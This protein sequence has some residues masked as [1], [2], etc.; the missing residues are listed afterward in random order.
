MPG[1]K[2]SSHQRRHFHP[3][4]SSA[5]V[6][7]SALSSGAEEIRTTLSLE[8]GVSP[9]GVCRKACA[10]PTAIAAAR[11]PLAGSWRRIT[12]MMP[13]MTARIA[14]HDENTTGRVTKIKVLRS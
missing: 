11:T 3:D 6:S 1:T 13:R 5:N 14:C 2:K 12:H 7:T 9:I 10:T 4:S 8:S